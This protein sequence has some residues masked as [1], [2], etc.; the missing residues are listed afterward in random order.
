MRQVLSLGLVLICAGTLL[1]ANPS[2]EDILEL[3]P[4]AGGL[5]VHIGRG[6]GDATRPA[7]VDEVGAAVDVAAAEHL[8][9]VPLGEAPGLA[10]CVQA[11]FILTDC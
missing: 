10:Q 3:A 4:T 5:V 6:D 11:L 8:G 1:A 9:P 2:A 7:F